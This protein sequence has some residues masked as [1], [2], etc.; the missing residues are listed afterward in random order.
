M[1]PLFTSLKINANFYCHNTNKIVLMSMNILE[2]WFEILY[3]LKK[4]FKIIYQQY[5]VQK[6]SKHIKLSSQ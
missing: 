6:F 4:K 1:T 3:K 2:Y 5:S